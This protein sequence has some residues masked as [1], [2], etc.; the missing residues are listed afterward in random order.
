VEHLALI[1]AA[2]RRQ[3]PD[4]FLG[5]PIYWDYDEPFRPSKRT[6]MFSGDKP[7]PHPVYG[8]PVQDGTDENGIPQWKYQSELHAED[9]AGA[10]F[11]EEVPD[12][13]PASSKLRQ[14]TVLHGTWA[15]RRRI[16]ID[17]RARMRE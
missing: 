3:G 14:G 1:S 17:A 6:H 11:A 9:N 4:T 2:G 13:K 12:E 5:M 8:K 7:L 16:L 15:E 10:A